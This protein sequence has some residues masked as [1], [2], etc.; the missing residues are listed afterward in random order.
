VY[1]TAVLHIQA[2]GRIVSRYRK[3][4]AFWIFVVLS[5]YLVYVYPVVRIGAWF[6]LPYVSDWYTALSLWIVVSVG[7][8]LSFTARFTLFKS[9]LVNW[10]GVGFIFFSVCVVYELVRLFV[11]VDDRQAAGWLVLFAGVVSL[12][13]FLIAGRLHHNHMEIRSEKL[14][15]NYRIVQISDI[16]IGSRSAEF[17]HRIVRRINGLQPDYVMI[18]GDLLDTSRVG[19][20]ELAALGDIIATAYFIVGNHERYVGL[21]HVIPI[22]EELG[23]QVLRNNDSIVEDFQ[24]I[25]IDDD[26]DPQQ[27][28]RILPSIAIHPAKFRILLYHRPLGWPSAVEAGIELML[29]G[30]THNGQIVPFNWLVKRQF[31]LIQGLFREGESHLYVS[32]G[33]GTW[34]PVMRLGSK[35]E[36]TCIDLLAGSL[37]RMEQ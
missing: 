27:V 6:G 31:K 11:S 13:A 34:G 21:E 22:V 37:K 5:A 30:H 18:T 19:R 14:G 12:F 16:H 4:A 28:A 15:R 24:F 17:L 10:M 36:I 32:P 9:L 2:P 25:G 20:Q 35:N 3:L 8:W 26:D 1:H 23:L 29:S 7:L 33:T